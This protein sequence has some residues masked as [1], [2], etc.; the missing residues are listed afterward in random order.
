MTD[1]IRNW[2][3]KNKVVSINIK[4][5]SESVY[6]TEGVDADDIASQLE[7]VFENLPTGTLKLLG[8]TNSATNWA[9]AQSFMFDKKGSVTI[10]NGQSTGMYSQEQVQLMI[11]LRQKEWE[12]NRLL[13]QFNKLEAK[14][15]EHSKILSKVVPALENL[16]DD[17]P[18]N[19]KSGLEKLAEA[20]TSAK[21]LFGDFKIG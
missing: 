17:D 16:L 4:K 11:E 12:F 20:A 8:R 3:T 2:L 7:D 6:N 9:N 1:S 10:P 21:T 18:D 14:V 13:E 19:N 5:G 15:E